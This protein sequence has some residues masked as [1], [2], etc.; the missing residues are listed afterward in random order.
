MKLGTELKAARVA[1]GWP[2]S[3]LAQMVGITVNQLKGYESNRSLPRFMD[4]I[5]LM[6]AVGIPL[7]RLNDLDGGTS[8]NEVDHA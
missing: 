3:R 8:F 1:L 6:N 4:G 2:R 5:R 7:V